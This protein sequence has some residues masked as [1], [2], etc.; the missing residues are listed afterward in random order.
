MEGPVDTPPEQ[1]KDPVLE[2]FEVQYAAVKGDPR[3]F[4]KLVGLISA[5]EKLGDIAKLREVY[6]AFFAEY[7]LCFGYWK[8]FADAENRH[9]SPEAALGVYERGVAAIPYSVDL[10]GHY[11]SF[12]QTIG[13][14]SEDVQSVFER[15]LQFVGTDYAAY[16]LWS[17]YINYTAGNGGSKAAALIYR[18]ALGQPLKELDK[19]FNSLTDFVSQLTVDQVVPDE[20]RAA[21][22]AQV[23]SMQEAAFAAQQKAAEEAET[24]ACNA[25]QEAAE[26]AAAAATVPAAPMEM[27][28]APMA[29][30]GPSTPGTERK[31]SAEEMP[32]AA[33]QTPPPTASGAP[34]DAAADADGAITPPPASAPAAAPAGSAADQTTGAPEGGAESAASAEELILLDTNVTDEDVKEA[35]LA[36]CQA[37]YE[38]SKEEVGRR[39]VFEDAIKR[40]YFH[41]KALDGAQLAAWSRLLDYAEER[42]DNSVTTHLYERCLVACAQYHDFWARYIRFLEPREPEA[43]KDAM[44]RAQGIHCKAQP[45]MQL[46]AARFLE[47][48]GDIAAARAA[49]ELVLSKLAPGLVSAVLACANFERRQGV[50]AA[51]CR[52]FDDAVAAAAEKGPQGEKTYAFLVVSHAHF[53]MQSY[54]DIDAARAAFAAALQKAPGSIT[55][56]EGA[57]HLEES[58]DAPGEEKARKALALYAKAAGSDTVL[59]EAE[60][61]DFSARAA[62]AADLLGTAQMVEMAE[63]L[64]CARFRP[65]ERL[66]RPVSS[67]S[68]PSSGQ[69]RPADASAAGASPA[70]KQARPAEHPAAS[71]APAAAE[72]TAA[73]AAAPAAVPAAAPAAAPAYYGQAAYG[74]PGYYAQYPQ[75]AYPTYTYPQY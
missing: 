43:A 40:P 37:I 44:L 23:K 73:S 34:Q 63:R 67:A 58:V 46:L 1:Q 33:P 19:C 75:Q 18:R 62:A 29:L 14:S 41:V 9:G 20:E 47:R 32:A 51:A 28:S 6:D 35:W 12:K 68:R 26:H 22:E 4:N 48:H 65:T 66:T 24:A 8:K 30:D 36:G 39:K 52:I 69:K 53:L 60:R 10:W 64:H 15:G 49:Y 17:K 27:P 70:N 11:A 61:E 31:A 45:E 55:L 57:I 54:K 56:W 59:S 25:A 5:A 16:G 2:A 7:P 50:K 71:Y 13:A 38:A 72:A 3:D 21:L 42:G 74:Y